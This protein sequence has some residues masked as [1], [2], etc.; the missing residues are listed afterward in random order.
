MSLIA[1]PTDLAVTRFNLSLT[2]SQRVS[3]APFGGSEQAVDLLNDRWLLSVEVG[4][5]SYEIASQVESFINAMRGQTNTVLLWHFARPT[6]RGTLVGS[7]TAQGASQGASS[8]VLNTTTGYTLKAGDLIG[9]SDLLLQVQTDCTAAAS[10]IT[11]PIVNRLRKA[12]NNGAAVTWDKPTAIFRL[13]S[14]SSVLYSAD[15]SESASIDFG[16]SI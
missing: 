10:A 13:L 9:V 14:K 12:I 5:Q 6:P 3:A 11:V 16:E 4:Q 1:W 8:I 2:V 7:P 15:T